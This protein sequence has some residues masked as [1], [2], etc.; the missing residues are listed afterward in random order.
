MKAI[1]T[2]TLTKI[3]DCSFID[4]WQKRTKILQSFLD[5]KLVI[6]VAEAIH[7]IDY[8]KILY[9]S[10]DGNYSRI[11]L[12]DGQCIFC[13]KTLK[14]FE[15]KLI[16]KKFLRVHSAHL[17]NLEHVIGISREQGF[18]IRLTNKINIPVSRVFKSQ[19]F[20]GSLG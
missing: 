1:Q 7:M 14:V 17:V 16:Y 15:L 11:Y 9:I 2:S 8:S 20:T 4:I 3:S 5:D 13:S 6:S 19:L 10:A 18:S 12:V